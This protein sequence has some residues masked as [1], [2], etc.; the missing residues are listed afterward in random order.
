MRASTS[1]SARKGGE[2][3][4]YPSGKQNKKSEILNTIFASF[5]IP[6]FPGPP[7]ASGIFLN[8]HELSQFLV[9]VAQAG[10][11]HGKSSLQEQLQE[12]PWEDPE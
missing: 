10:N 3:K 8:Y 7:P 9:G 6:L 11:K 5:L 4:I 1:V 12:L 2:K